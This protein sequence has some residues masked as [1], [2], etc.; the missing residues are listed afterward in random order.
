VLDKGFA[1]AGIAKSQIFITNV[2]HCHPQ[3]NRPSL[4]HEIANC[5]EYLS[6][7]L[8]I[9][10]PRMIIAL[11]VDAGSHLQEWVTRDGDE[12]AVTPGVPAVS[13]QRRVLMLAKHPSWVMKQKEPVRVAYVASFA[14]ALRWAFGG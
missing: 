5:A 4:P 2:V 1:A 12:W 11:G 7:E 14:S 8:R 13:E 3:K 6:D 9:I 10:H